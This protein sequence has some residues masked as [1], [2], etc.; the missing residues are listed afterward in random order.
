MM[1]PG[2][3]IPYSVTLFDPAELAEEVAAGGAT[4]C[5]LGYTVTFHPRLSER[6]W[7][8]ALSDPAKETAD[9]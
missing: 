6:L 8:F 5:E 4:I 3:N 7:E 2:W 1:V 9:V